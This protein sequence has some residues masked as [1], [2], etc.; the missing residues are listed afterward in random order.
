ML[1]LLVACSYV[2]ASMTDLLSTLDLNR[3]AVNEKMAALASYMYKRKLPRKLQN[4]VNTYYRNYLEK[5]TGLNESTIISELSTNLQVSN[6]SS[7][8]SRV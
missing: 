6:Y 7:G 5:K 1:L 2:I 4:R 8:Y 3:R